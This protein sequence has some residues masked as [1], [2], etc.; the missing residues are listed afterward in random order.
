VIDSMLANS[1]LEKRDRAL[2]AFAILSGAR[3]DAIA[4]MLI[5]HVDPVRRTVFHDARDVGRRTAR[6]S[7]S[8]GNSAAG[9]DPA[10]ADVKGS[11]RSGGDV[12]VERLEWPSI[13]RPAGRSALRLS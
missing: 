7:R 6:L 5:R 3:D 2:I 11:L 8:T 10:R 13:G 1:D 4:S 9:L 12:T